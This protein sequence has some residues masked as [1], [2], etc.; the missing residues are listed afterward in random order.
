[1]P[2]HAPALSPGVQA[3]A[4]LLKVAPASLA[5][6][7]SPKISAPGPGTLGRPQFGRNWPTMAVS[8]SGPSSSPSSKSPAAAARPT[9]CGAFFLW[10]VFSVSSLCAHV[11]RQRLGVAHLHAVIVLLL[12][13]HGTF[14]PATHLSL[15]APSIRRGQLLYSHRPSRDEEKSQDHRHQYL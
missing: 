10:G 15:L 13:A 3:G 5:L 6:A 12:R 2:L 8:A 1:M 9:I 11:T 7:S 14:V 4:F